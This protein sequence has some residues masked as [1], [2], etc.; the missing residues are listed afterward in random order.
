M[1]KPKKAW[2]ISVVVS[3]MLISCI[4]WAKIRQHQNSHHAYHEEQKTE[5]SLYRIVE[6]LHFF[7]INALRFRLSELQNIKA[8][9]IFMREKDCPISEK[10]G[11]RIAALEK[12]YS[13]KGIQ[14]IYN[15]VGQVNKQEAAEEDLRKFKFKGAY[16]VDD[17]QKVIQALSVQTTGEVF[18]LTPEREIVYRGP[19]DDQYHLLRSALRAKNHYVSDILD[20]IVL[21][22]KVKSKEFSAPGC[23]ISR[24]TIKK[25][26]FLND[27]ASIIQRKC[28]ICHN[29]YGSGQINYSSY[30]DVASRGTMF[31]YVIEN[32]LMPPWF[33]H[34]NTA[35]FKNDM[36]LTLYEKAI[37]MKWILTGFKK[38]KKKFLFSQEKFME[39]SVI[40]NPNYFIRPPEKIKIKNSGFMPYKRFNIKTNLQEDKWIK[41]VEFVVHPKVVHHVVFEIHGQKIPKEDICSNLNQFNTCVYFVSRFSWGPGIKK[42]TVWPFNT[43]IKIPAKAEIF[44]EIHYEPI[45]E[46]IIDDMTEVRFLFHKTP[47]KNQLVSLKLYDTLIKIPSG[48]SNYKSEMA[49]RLKESFEL[50]GVTVHMHLRGKASSIS[51]I[52]PGEKEETGKTVFSLD[53][54]HFNFHRNYWFK[55]PIKIS[56]G[57]ILKCLNWFDNSSRN[58]VNPDPDRTVSWGL[59][60]KDEMSTC[61]FFFLKNSSKN[62]F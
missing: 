18:I 41:E 3:I 40:K 31:K 50:I 19:V 59:Q 54:W 26:V 51:I 27:V 17:R 33:A 61:A 38:K 13:K 56:K 21:G 36:R 29:P 14:F 2:I 15:Y 55:K 12:Q 39:K 25:E 34:S 24:P 58:P 43:G 9:V 57:S 7:P 6:D 44:L 46:E 53:P 49:Y 35:S 52:E 4:H 42:H 1:S 22:R 5:F 20:S 37:L 16:V 30:E 47:P 60:T 23:V 45:G 32:D 11:P 8:I 10:Y 28:V 48:D 62:I